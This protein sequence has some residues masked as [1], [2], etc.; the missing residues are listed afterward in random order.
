MDKECSYFVLIETFI[1]I[2]CTRELRRLETKNG[3][4][5]PFEKSSNYDVSIHL[6]RS[7]FARIIFFSLWDQLIIVHIQEMVVVLAIYQIMLVWL[8]QEK[9][10]EFDLVN[11]TTT[12]VRTIHFISFQK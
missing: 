11:R 6:L 9:T 1:L 7:L 12:S 8:Y 5:L 10:F 4:I 3:S 2:Q